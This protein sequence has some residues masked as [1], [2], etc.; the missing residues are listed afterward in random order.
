MRCKQ[1]DDVVIIDGKGCDKCGNQFCGYCCEFDN[2][3]ICGDCL[4]YDCHHLNEIKR[5][6]AS[7]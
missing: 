4:T 1:C 2:S 7:K 5:E 6:K 3:P